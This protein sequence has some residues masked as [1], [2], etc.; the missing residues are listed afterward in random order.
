MI[1]RYMGDYFDKEHGMA[2]QICIMWNDTILVSDGFCAC[3]LTT[4]V[5]KWLNDNIRGDDWRF[6][7]TA[8]IIYFK[9]DIDAMLF[10]L[11]WS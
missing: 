10:I 1:Y 3:R 6:S 4:R 5:K 11:A 7:P 9:N 2:H 8:Q